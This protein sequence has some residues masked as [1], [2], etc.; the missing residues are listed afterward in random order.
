MMTRKGIYY[1]TFYISLY[2]GD[3]ISDPFYP[4]P[5]GRMDHREVRTYG[6]GYQ[7]PAH[8]SVYVPLYPVDYR[9]ESHCDR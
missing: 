2:C 6:E 3:R 4:D 8:C 1:D 9:S 5:S 7:F